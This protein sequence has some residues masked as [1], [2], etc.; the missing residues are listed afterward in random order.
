MYQHPKEQTYFTIAAIIGGVIWLGII[1]GTMG[2]A[3]ICFV[4]LGFILWIAEKFLEASLFGDAIHVS[5]SQYSEINDRVNQ[6]AERMDL[7]DVP[8]IFILN[9]N[10]ISN[11]LAVKFF[12]GKYILLFSDLIDNTIFGDDTSA[13]D[14][15]IAHELAHHKMGHLSLWKTLIVKPSMFIPFLGSAYS[16][17]CE[18]TADGVAS[19]MTSTDAGS[20]SL[21]YLSVGSLKL[22]QRVCPDSFQRQELQINSFFG[23]LSEILQSHPRM[24]KRI[25]HFKVLNLIIHTQG[26]TMPPKIP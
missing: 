12:T 9:G 10:G 4:F 23:Y 25:E 17:A 2:L 18:Y 5:E 22:A 1:A 20:R 24:T 26:T 21:S 13:L 3:L 7:V 16:R 14:F 19:Q 11:A 8:K 15:I 6:M